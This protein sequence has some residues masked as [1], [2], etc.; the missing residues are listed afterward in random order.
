M[1]FV[2]MFCFCSLQSCVSVF[3][4]RSWLCYKF[5]VYEVSYGGGRGA[6]FGREILFPGERG[7]NGALFCVQKHLVLIQMQPLNKKCHLE[8]ASVMV[9]WREMTSCFHFSLFVGLVG[10]FTPSYRQQRS[11]AA[12]RATPPRDDLI[13]RPVCYPLWSLAGLNSKEVALLSQ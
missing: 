4:S 11:G 7:H 10:C 12:V 6:S 2:H 13:L 8:I 9:V 5:V 1:N 3:V